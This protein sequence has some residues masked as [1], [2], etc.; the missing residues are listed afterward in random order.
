MHHYIPRGLFDCVQLTSSSGSPLSMSFTLY[1]TT[2]VPE[3]EK[4]MTLSVNV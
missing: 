2:S 1:T 3:E 4:G